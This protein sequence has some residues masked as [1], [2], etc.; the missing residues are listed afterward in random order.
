MLQEGPTR[1]DKPVLRPL[2]AIHCL[3]GNLIRALISWAGSDSRLQRGIGW[4][5]QIATGKGSVQYYASGANDK[6]PCAWGATRAPLTFARIPP[7]Q[8]PPIVGRAMVDYAR[9]HFRFY[10]EHYRGLPTSVTEIQQLPPVTKPELMLRFDG[11]VTASNVG[12]ADLERWIGD[13]SHLGHDCCSRHRVA[14]DREHAGD[15]LAQ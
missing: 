10:A 9:A 2:R 15:P 8:P 3:T 1:D 6:L 4:R 13:L 5:A 7:A 11:W 14:D 12:R